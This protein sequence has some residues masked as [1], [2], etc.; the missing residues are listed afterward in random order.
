MRWMR[1]GESGVPSLMNSSADLGCTH[2]CWAGLSRAIAWQ[3]LRRLVLRLLCRANAQRILV[4][5]RKFL[6]RM[7]T[8]ERRDSAQRGLFSL[9]GNFLA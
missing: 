9:A 6:E 8:G 4:L 1:K 5:L 3:V 7:R 2:H